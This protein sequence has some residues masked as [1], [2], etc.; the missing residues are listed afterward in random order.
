MFNKFFR[1]PK[2]MRADTEGLGVDLFMA[3]EVVQKH[4]GTV[5]VRSEGEGKGA[6]FSMSLPIEKSS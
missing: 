3:K 5:S 1:T 2:A 4:G 6:T